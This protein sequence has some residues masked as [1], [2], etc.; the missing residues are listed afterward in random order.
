MSAIGFVPLDTN[1]EDTLLKII[2]LT[3][4]GQDEA[5]IDSR[6]FDR[7]T[8]DRLVQLGYISKLDASTLSGWGYIVSLTYSGKNY[9]ELK[10][11][12][13]HKNRGSQIK[14]WSK[15]LIP[16]LIALGSLIVAIISLCQKGG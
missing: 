10:R 9:K 7:G 13:N 2:T 11:Q 6:D 16:T 14:K 12:Y 1:L 3:N 8:V 5:S 4:G 15:F